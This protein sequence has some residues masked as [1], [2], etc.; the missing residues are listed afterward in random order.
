MSALGRYGPWHCI[1]R[2]LDA[3]MYWAHLLELT[4][5]TEHHITGVKLLGAPNWG[6]HAGH[7]GCVV[8]FDPRWDPSRIGAS[9]ELLLDVRFGH[10][11]EIQQRHTGWVVDPHLAPDKCHVPVYITHEAASRVGTPHEVRFS[12]YPLFSDFETRL[13]MRFE[14]SDADPP[15]RSPFPHS[16]TC[17]RNSA[18]PLRPTKWP[19]P[20]AV[21]EPEVVVVRSMFEALD[22]AL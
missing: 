20:P 9:S 18:H 2:K 1:R 7:E 6:Q 15:N 19:D 12:G 5:W 11:R 10:E 4:G 16:P 3:E 21:P 8:S 14:F 13:C 17:P 22:D